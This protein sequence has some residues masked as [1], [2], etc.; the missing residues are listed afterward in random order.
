M[1]RR[2]LPRIA[3]GLLAA[4]IVLYGGDTVVY[5]LRGSPTDQ[6]TVNQYQTIP[7]K[8]HKIEYDYIGTE[9]VTCSVSLFPQA[10]QQACWRLRR[11]PNQT[12]E[13]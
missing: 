9:S 3:A 7:L 1:I 6:V 13:L 11:N 2:W 10:G 8:G 5:K 12:T 4:C